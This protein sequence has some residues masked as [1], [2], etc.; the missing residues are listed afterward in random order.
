MTQTEDIFC[1][2]HHHQSDFYVA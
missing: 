2:R 1:H